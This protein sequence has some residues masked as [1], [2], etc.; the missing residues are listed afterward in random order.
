KAFRFRFKAFSFDFH[1][2][3]TLLNGFRLWEFAVRLQQHVIRLRQYA[4]LL[5]GFADGLREIVIRL[6][7]L[8]FW[9]LLYGLKVWVTVAEQ[10]FA[11]KWYWVC[12]KRCNFAAFLCIRFGKLYDDEEI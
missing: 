11:V 10:L 12:E 5:R 6:R 9:G 7:L 3:K 4:G 2:I 8:A 1:G